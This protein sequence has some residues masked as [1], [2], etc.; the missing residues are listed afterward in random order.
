MTR[1]PCRTASTTGVAPRR[2]TLCTADP[3]APGGQAA[4]VSRRMDVRRLEY[5][6]I[7]SIT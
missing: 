5:F 1:H 2:R 7:P 3:H 6:R 4:S